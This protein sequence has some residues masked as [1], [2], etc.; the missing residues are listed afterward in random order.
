MVFGGSQGQPVRTCGMCRIT[1]HLAGNLIAHRLIYVAAG[2]YY[3][4]R[5]CVAVQQPVFLSW[6]PGHAWW[7]TVF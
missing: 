7:N 2:V 4:L 3:G 1:S 6:E 5:Q